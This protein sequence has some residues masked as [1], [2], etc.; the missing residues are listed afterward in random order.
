MAPTRFTGLGFKDH[1]KQ[2][3]VPRFSWQKKWSRHSCKSYIEQYLKSENLTWSNL[4]WRATLRWFLRSQIIAK[5]RRCRPQAWNNHK[6]LHMA[7]R[8]TRDRHRHQV[9][10]DNDKVVGGVEIPASGDISP[11]HE[12]R[13]ISKRF[14]RDS[15]IIS[16]A[17]ILWAR[18]RTLAR[19]S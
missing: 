4:T 11:V 13:Q 2:T 3:K 1:T 6:L 18:E 17:N 5:F 10:R 14:G 19:S 15:S 16:S 9:C 12:S 8:L 7:G